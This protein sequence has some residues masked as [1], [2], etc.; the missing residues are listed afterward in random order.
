MDRINIVGHFRVRTVVCKAFFVTKHEDR[1]QQKLEE[2]LK[3]LEVDTEETRSF[4]WKI[5]SFEDKLRQLKSNG[6]R[7][8][9]SV[10]FSAYGYKLMLRLYPN[11]VAAGENTHLSRFMVILKGEYDAI[12]PWGFSKQ[13]KFTLIDQQDDPNQR[14]NHVQIPQKSL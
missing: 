1:V 4:L 8:I 12:S 9:K 10:P 14:K 3:I 5:T 2:E 11:G 13:V 6:R 7:Y